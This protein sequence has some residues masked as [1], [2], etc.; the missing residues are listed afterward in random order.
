MLFTGR[1]KRLSHDACTFDCIRERVSDPGMDGPARPTAD[2]ASPGPNG[3]DGMSID[4]GR[5]V[6]TGL[7]RDAPRPTMDG[8]VEA[9]PVVPPADAAESD[10]APDAVDVALSWPDVTFGLPET[11]SVLPDVPT[12]VLDAST[13]APDLLANGTDGAPE[14]DA[15]ADAAW[16]LPDMTS[17]LPDMVL[18]PP[19]MTLV[20][21]D[22]PTLVLDAPTPGLDLIGG[23]SDGV[24]GQDGVGGP[25]DAS[26]DAPV[27]TPG[28]ADSPSASASDSAVTCGN[29][30]P[31]FVLILDT[32]S[33]MLENSLGRDTHGDG[34]PG[35][36]GCNL[37][38][39]TMGWPYDDSSLYQAKQAISDTLPALT[40]AEF[41]LA[42]FRGI[43]LGQACS[44]DTDCP[45]DP[46]AG[47]QLYSFVSCVGPDDTPCAG[48][49]GC[50]CLYRA[51]SY[52]CQSN[53][54]AGCNAATRE[55]I[56]FRSTACRGSTCVWPQCKAAEILVPF[57][58]A[59]SSTPQVLAWTNGIEGPGDPEIRAD[60]GTPLGSSIDSVREWLTSSTATDVGPLAGPMGTDQDG[61][62]RGH[63]II[64]FTDGEE[65]C[66]SDPT[67]AAGRVRQTCT[68]G[69]TWDSTDQRCEIAGQH[70]GTRNLR[71]Y[72]IGFGAATGL[73][74]RLNAIAVAGG[75]SAA[76]LPTT[77]SAFVA[78]M[79]DIVA[80]ARQ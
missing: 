70:N 63:D 35:Y 77:R 66:K 73:E 71:V 19:D 1:R 54:P 6:D 26:I 65:T 61:A 40:N 33:G 42:R 75:T 16:V 22:V 43:D 55:F 10:A 2:A 4:L 48:R 59:G 21:G 64:L 38:G 29:A 36:E 7:E 37:D 68:N 60:V 11:L 14:Q 15:P 56:S 30:K 79:N 24:A 74:G 9:T 51:Y 58:V 78:A 8:G 17:G 5:S 67:S 18:V 57:A 49:L 28:M 23:G 80:R 45:R 50:R 69:G 72:V 27:D 62:C 25:L 53:C 32:S 13:P 76:Y 12:P 20:L 41:A 46:S 3:P 34:S 44:Q 39:N 47:N 52:K 31:R